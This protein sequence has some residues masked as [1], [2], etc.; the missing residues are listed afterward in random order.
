MG[1]R[2]HHLSFDH[3]YPRGKIITTTKMFDQTLPVYHG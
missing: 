1:F 3:R 2:G